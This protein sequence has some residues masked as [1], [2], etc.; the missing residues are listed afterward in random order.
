MLVMLNE[1]M[2]FLNWADEVWQTYQSSLIVEGLD[3]VFD[4]VV[5]QFRNQMILGVDEIT[6]EGNFVPWEDAVLSDRISQISGGLGLGFVVNLQCLDGYSLA[7]F[8]DFRRIAGHLECPTNRQDDDENDQFEHFN[9]R[10]TN[11][12]CV[13]HVFYSYKTLLIR[14]GLH[15]ML[16]WIDAVWSGWNCLYVKR[17]R[18]LI[19][20]LVARA[21][22]WFV[23]IITTSWSNKVLLIIICRGILTRRRYG[24]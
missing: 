1:T 14:C 3:G 20:Y 22:T 9:F 11:W 13:T 6:R 24:V 23:I 2:T 21:S 4:L 8:V 15:K 18:A 16:H 19:K 7:L 12:H 5:S 10:F 17:R